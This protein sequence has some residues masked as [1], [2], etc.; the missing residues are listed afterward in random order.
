MSEICYEGVQYGVA[1]AAERAR[2]ESLFSNDYS[3]SDRDSGG[4]GS[5]YDSGGSSAGGSSGGGFR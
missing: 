4:G 1:R 2:R 3:G 5:S